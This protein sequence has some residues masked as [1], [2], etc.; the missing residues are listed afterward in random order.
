[1]LLNMPE[2]QGISTRNKKKKKKSAK[3][4]QH[5]KKVYTFASF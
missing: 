2:N 4:V 5:I 3:R 1:M